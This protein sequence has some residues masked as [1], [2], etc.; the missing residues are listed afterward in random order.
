MIM[1]NNMK[2]CHS[3]QDTNTV[4]FLMSIGFKVGCYMKQ[5]IELFIKSEQFYGQDNSDIIKYKGIGTIYKKR[6]KYYLIYN[7]KNYDDA[8]TSIKLEPDEERI[9]VHRVKPE[10]KQSFEY[11]SKTKGNYITPYGVF[12]LEIDTSLLTIELGKIKGAF[13]VKYKL[14]LNG[15]YTSQ[16]YLSISWD[17]L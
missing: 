13:H 12:E 10:L 11:G 15:H 4:V 14:Y 5:E 16:N 6:D 9:F 1:Y 7:D 2:R 8:R 3:R 17:I